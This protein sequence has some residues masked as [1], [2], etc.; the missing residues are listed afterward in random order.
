MSG[1]ILDG[2][3]MVERM[4]R[5]VKVEESFTLELDANPTTGYQ[6]ELVAISDMRVLEL[7]RQTYVPDLPVGIGTGGKELLTFKGL[8]KGTAIISLVY[9]RPW[10]PHQPNLLVTVTVTDA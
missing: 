4:T 1:T 6:W 8:K 3:R 5:T 10:E 2:S 7:T 9:D